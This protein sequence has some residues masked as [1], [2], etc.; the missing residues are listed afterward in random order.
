MFHSKNNLR[1]EKFGLLSIEIPMFL[2]QGK[3]VTSRTKIEHKVQIVLRSK[4]GMQLYDERIWVLVELAEYIP[5]A[6][7]LL[8]S[9]HVSV[10][11][12]LR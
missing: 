5:L 2:N 7:Y 10:R 11:Q 6:D 1:K 3:Q 9:V 12:L 8:D 4:G